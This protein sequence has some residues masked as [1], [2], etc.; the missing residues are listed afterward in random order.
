MKVPKKS[1]DSAIFL[2]HKYC[3]IK[4][5]F[6]SLKFQELNG[7]KDKFLQWVN[8]NW[9]SLMMSIQTTKEENNKLGTLSKQ[10]TY[11][12][13]VNMEHYKALGIKLHRVNKRSHLYIS[14]SEPVKSLIKGVI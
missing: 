1:R 12:Q 9:E 7:D 8:D 5:N 14:Y 3:V 10:M 2:N 13:K 11:E 6:H 4:S